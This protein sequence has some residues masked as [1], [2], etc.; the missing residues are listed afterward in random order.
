MPSLAPRPRETRRRVTVPEGEWTPIGDAAAPGG[1][2]GRL[3]AVVWVNKVAMRIELVD[4][5]LADALV[6][7]AAII[8]RRSPPRLR[9]RGRRYVVVGLFMP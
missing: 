4:E 8:E 1:V 3:R 5:D 9:L 6:R 7:D 2:D